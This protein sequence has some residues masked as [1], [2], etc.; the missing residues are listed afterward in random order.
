MSGRK[1]R[2]INHNYMRSLW[3]L[4]ILM[5]A[6]SFVAKRYWAAIFQSESMI[7]LLRLPGYKESKI[8]SR[9]DEAQPYKTLLSLRRN[10]QSRNMHEK[11]LSNPLSSRF[12]S[13]GTK[14]SDNL[15]L[16]ANP[17]SVDNKLIQTVIKIVGEENEHNGSVNGYV[18]QLLYFLLAQ[19]THD[20]AILGANLRAQ[21]VMSQLVSSVLTSMQFILPLLVIGERYKYY[22]WMFAKLWLIYV[23]KMLSDP[24]S[25]LS[26]NSVDYTLSSQIWPTVTQCMFK[27]YGYRG[28]EVVNAMCI[29]SINE[30]CSKLFVVIWWVVALNIVLEIYCLVTLLFCSLNHNLIKWTF[31]LRFWPGARKEADSIATF[32]YRHA[33]VLERILKNSRELGGSS[34]SL[35]DLGSHCSTEKSTIRCQT[36]KG[37]REEKLSYRPP[38]FCYKLLKK[39]R[40]PVQATRQ[41]R[42]GLRE[43]KEDSNMYFLLYLLY[44]RLGSSRGEIEVVLKSTSRVLDSYLDFISHPSESNSGVLDS[45]ETPA[46][47]S[48]VS[49]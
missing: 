12:D 1:Y 45:D 24:D 11:S 42:D 35:N 43:M 46:F 21:V 9:V 8:A 47:V 44:L 40:R 34:D 22:G 18:D 3:P 5:A 25:T 17:E 4:L 10:H 32:R 49:R 48:V 14:F 6:C 36:E 7:T 13:T 28:Q 19:G 39:L 41:D 23:H 16:N 27:Q 20:R 2:L 29:V 33:R 15:K 37:Q 38:G 26:L 30:I 31:G